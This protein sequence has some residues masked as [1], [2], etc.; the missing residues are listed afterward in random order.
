[1]FALGG[2]FLGYAYIPGSVASTEYTKTM[3]MAYGGQF[4]QVILKMLVSSVIQDIFNPY[5]R[6]ILVG[7]LLMGLNAAYLLTT[8]ETFVNEGLLF[9][10]V[11][12]LSWGAIF[13]YVYYTL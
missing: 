13:H 10:A 9:L 8:G 11:C 5:R 12:V 4:T 6:T 1:M 7:W 2:M 3:M